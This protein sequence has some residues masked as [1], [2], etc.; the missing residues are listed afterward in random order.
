MS[1]ELK[2]IN[3]CLDIFIVCQ[4]FIIIGFKTQP[5]TIEIILVTSEDVGLV[6]YT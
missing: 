2:K 3:N 1:S 6:Y 4:V 5:R